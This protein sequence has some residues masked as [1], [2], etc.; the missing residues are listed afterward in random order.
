MGTLCLV[1]LRSEEGVGSPGVKD[2][3]KA[4]YGFWELNLDS[5]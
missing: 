5:L 2:G 3:C 4:L 1:P